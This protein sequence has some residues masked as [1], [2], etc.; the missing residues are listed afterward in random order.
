MQA[1]RE[2]TREKRFRIMLGRMA[3]GERMGI[4]PKKKRPAY[5]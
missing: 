1:K 4:L 2:E 3:K 5:L